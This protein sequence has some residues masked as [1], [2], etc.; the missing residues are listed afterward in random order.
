MPYTQEEINAGQRKI[1]GAL[2]EVDSRVILTLKEIL[3]A[4]KVV[5]ELPTVAPHLK[6]LNFDPLEKALREAEYFS[7]KVADINPPGCAAPPY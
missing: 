2:C 3:K 7:E 6:D 1:N 5:A 4:L